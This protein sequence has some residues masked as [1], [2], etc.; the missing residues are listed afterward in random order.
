MA[1]SADA[2]RY[3]NTAMA[4]D[5]LGAEIATAMDANTVKTGITSG[6]AAA[7]AANTLKTSFPYSQA[8]T[9]TAVSLTA[10]TAVVRARVSAILVKL[11]AAKL[12]A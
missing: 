10:T 11:K 9:V 12:M 6:Q 5:T 7:I 1:L 3:L 8:A 4:N 2:K